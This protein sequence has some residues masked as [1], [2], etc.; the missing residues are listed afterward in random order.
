MLD[1]RAAAQRAT[2]EA[3]AST[4]SAEQQCEALYWDTWNSVVCMW[5]LYR[6]RDET[7]RKKN[8]KQH[9]KSNVPNKRC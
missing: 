2:R 1:G 7:E 4:L 6:A 8:D 5:L 3:A 9:F